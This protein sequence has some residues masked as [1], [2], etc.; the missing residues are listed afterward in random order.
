[1]NPFS[2]DDE[3]DSIV[4][5]VTVRGLS[6]LQNMGNTCYMNSILQCITSLD[7]LRSWL[8]KDKYTKFIIDG[9]AKERR[10]KDNIPVDQKVE[11]KKSEIDAKCEETLVYNL[12]VLIQ[13]LWY[14]NYLCRP[15][16]FKKILDK[17]CPMFIGFRQHDSQELLSMILDIVHEETKSNVNVTFPYIPEDVTSY[18]QVKAECTEKINNENTSLED[19][20]K[21]LVYLKQYQNTHLDNAII[22]DS[23]LYWK[24][25]IEKSHSI[26]TDL[27][28][29][30]YYS[31]IICQE[32]QNIT[33]VFDP[34]TILSLPTQEQGETTLEES[35]QKFVSTELLTDQ[36]QYFC[37]E[38][39]KK[40]NAIKKI[41]IWEPPNILIIQ[42][43][44]FKATQRFRITKTNS[45]VKFPLDG[46]DI[47]DYLS[48]IHQINNTIYDLHAISDHNGSCHSGHYIA[49]CKNSINKKWYKFND[50]RVE[51]IPTE[52]LEREVVTK[53]AYILFY[54]RRLDNDN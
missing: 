51:Y 2:D 4:D 26:I 32:C 54:V 42:L 53:N 12:A 20:E 8:L 11:L 7:F 45:T 50:E 17:K 19:K 21:F 48:D 38:C 14:R 18:L 31:K 29:G 39:K 33:W 43:K 46:L 23:Y 25:Y 10:K 13:T 52:A 22:G 37:S 27:F 49:Y 34:F 35:L 36:E 41:H 9:L 3:D 15:V 1:M 24:K 47:Q 28:T 30:L 16:S 5:Q 44:R 40:V 6:G